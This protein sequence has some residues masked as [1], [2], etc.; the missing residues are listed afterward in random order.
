MLFELVGALL[1]QDQTLEIRVVTTS[2]SHRLGQLPADRGSHPHLSIHRL[3]AP[4]LGSRNIYVRAVGGALFTLRALLALAFASKPDAI[5]VVTNPPFL[6]FAPWFVSRIFGVPYVYVIHDLYPDVAVSIGAIES[7]SVGARL[8]GLMQARWLRDAR[9]VVVLGRCARDVVASR[10]RVSR[11]KLTVIPNWGSAQTIL[12]APKG[13]FLREHHGVDGFIV[14][15]AGNLG[16]FHEFA[17]TVNAAQQLQHRAR[18]VTFVFVG[19]GSQKESLQRDVALLGLD[20][21]AFLPFVTEE[22]LPELLASADAC[23]VTLQAA[24]AGLSVPSKLYNAMAAARP[25]LA[26]VPRESEVALVV[27][28]TGCGIHILPGDAFRLASCVE[29][30]LASPGLCSQM[31][32][33]GRE[34][35]ESRY[36]V[37]R[38]APKYRSVLYRAAG[39]EGGLLGSVDLGHSA[40][41]GAPDMAQESADKWGKG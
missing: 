38:S 1:D 34:A 4:L 27:E 20:N 39:L 2:R 13:G 37:A 18:P 8:F 32:L 5:L 35:V 16:R 41:A 30:L 15:Y 12:P 6:A 17:T 19:D 36:S 22:Q 3:T 7:G 31:G 14:L 26:V 28:E 25:V 29:D 10:Y 9:E 24:A 21:I 40:N 11:S 33:R 23:L